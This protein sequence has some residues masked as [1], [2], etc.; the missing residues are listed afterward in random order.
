MLEA[1]NAI[2][3]Y[4]IICISET[5]LNCLQSGNDPALKR[6]GNELIRYDHPNNTKRGGVCLY[7]KENLP[8]QFG[9]MYED[10]HTPLLSANFCAQ[11]ITA[12]SL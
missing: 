8:L 6:K 12:A 3:D 7:Y 11:Q 10:K 1:Y 2:H 5:Y 4:G 9:T